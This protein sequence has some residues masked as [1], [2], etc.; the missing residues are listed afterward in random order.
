[1]EPRKSPPD[2]GNDDAAD[3]QQTSFLAPYLSD[4]KLYLV[5]VYALIIYGMGSF[6]FS[7]LWILMV[8]PLWI[9]QIRQERR[10]RLKRSFLT[11]FE[12]DP[13]K[14][15]TTI[16]PELPS[17]VF[18]A[19]TEKALWL[20]EII[21]RLWPCVGDYVE[22]YLR[23]LEPCI[24]EKMTELTKFDSFKFVKMVL[25][26]TPVKIYGIKVFPQTF[27]RH[28]IVMDVD[29]YYSGDC[30]FQVALSKLKAGIRDIRF[31]GIIR[32]VMKPL[33]KEIPLIGGLQVFFLRDPEIDF[34][35]TEIANILD[36]PGIKE[37]LIKTVNDVLHSI[38]VLPNKL[39]I[40]LISS[41]P[42]TVF[43][44]PQP[45]GVLRINLIEAENLM[46]KDITLFSGKSDP[47][48][49]ISVGDQEFRTDIIYN[50][51]NPQWN[52]V[53]EAL[54]DEIHGQT[55]DIKV[56]DQ[57]TNNKDDELGS[58]FLDIQNIV[59][60]G[61]ID[62]WITLERAES[63]KIHLQASWFSL[64]NDLLKLQQN[65]D[66]SAQKKYLSTCVLIVYIESA[67][68]LPNATV[69]TL[70][71]PSPFASVI[72]DSGKY[73]SRVC[74]ET[75]SPQ[76]DQGFC[77]LVND[78]EQKALSIEISDKKTSNLLGRFHYNIERLKYEDN[79]KIHRAFNLDS[80]GPNSHI[81]VGL[82]LKIMTLAAS[83]TE[84]L[85]S[86]SPITPS[87]V[88]FVNVT[89]EPPPEP[90][91]SPVDETPINSAQPIV[92][93]LD[94]E[95]DTF[96]NTTRKR[97]VEQHESADDG[98]CAIQMTFRYSSQR[99]VLGVVIHKV[100]NIPVYNSS[101]LPDPYIKLQLWPG[102][103]EYKRKTTTIKNNCNP[104]YDE[105]FEFPVILPELNNR[106]L[107]VYVC[108]RSSSG[109]FGRSVIIGKKMIDIVDL[110]LSTTITKWFHLEITNEDNGGND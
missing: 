76:W 23:K 22:D 29:I 59:K 50:T 2:T 75:N 96:E 81:T 9:Y 28:E 85:A 78:P 26:D 7:L 73:E 61:T 3:Q 104:V 19:D 18:F 34:N 25:G 69:S 36:F 79:L 13:K 48:A 94:V 87:S 105:T 10:T 15:L 46:K 44:Y 91:S 83:E 77:L 82:E 74:D 41:L 101:D 56:R 90:E 80:S 102:S 8:I 21:K 5:I 38:M 110:D 63:G 12:A 58:V 30:Y 62:K 16:L 72:L 33:V 100:R 64:S 17:W 84:S 37:M 89:S 55:I 67:E 1:M 24:R 52:F 27:S 6:G 98:K 95:K 88:P 32:V 20:N 45:Q 103:K 11:E 86:S 66:D 106:T 51:I 40:K 35:L 97:H 68:N 49:K 31:R 57:D 65:L 93:S 14:M 54:V 107:Q 53:C 109:I 39:S 92:K 70:Q 43:N 42:D 4:L 47:Y 60:K 99:Q 108:S 71:E